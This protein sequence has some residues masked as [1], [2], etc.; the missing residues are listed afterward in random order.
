ML[1]AIRHS[2]I[3]LPF[4]AIVLSD[5]MVYV[6]VNEEDFESEEL[7]SAECVDEELE[8]GLVGENSFFFSCEDKVFS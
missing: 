8:E 3:S 6:D 2:T 4:V 5:E 7:E 1:V